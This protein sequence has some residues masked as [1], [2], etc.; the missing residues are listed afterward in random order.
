MK[1]DWKENADKRLHS[2][3]SRIASEVDSIRPAW[4]KKLYLFPSLI[5]FHSLVDLVVCIATS[6]ETSQQKTKSKAVRF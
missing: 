3:K 4:K 5:L 1:S 6:P 2:S